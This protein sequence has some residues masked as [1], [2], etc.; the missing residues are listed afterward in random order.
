MKHLTKI[1]LGLFLLNS[2]VA[3]AQFSSS[4]KVYCYEYVETDNDGIRSKAR[5][6]NYYF[7]NFQ[8]NMMGYSTAN[9]KQ[10]VKENLLK[11]EEYYNEEARNDLARDY[12]KWDSL[13][14]D[15]RSITYIYLFNKQYSSA[16][17]YTYQQCCKKSYYIPSNNWMSYGYIPQ[18]AWGQP[19]WDNNCYTF[20]TDKS[21]LII[22]SISDPD[23]K[24]YY[25]LV[26]IDD[27]KPNTDFLYE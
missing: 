25:K 17:K 9:R 27:L 15:A 19:E 24:D 14:N 23:K 12:N 4:S 21:E 11:N 6:T 1:L 18:Y 2:F 26:D 16:Y 5:E 8:G 3:S 22:W 7:F 20:S 13:P 10:T